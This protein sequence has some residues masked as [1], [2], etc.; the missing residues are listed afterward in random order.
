MTDLKRRRFLTASALGGAATLAMPAVARSEETVQWRMQALW[1]GGTT[2]FE[3]EKKFVERVAELTG[4]KF[5]I[6]LFS[7]GQLVPANQAFDAVRSGAFQMMKTF[8]GYEAGKIPSFAFTS[9]IPFGFPDPDQYEAWFYEL[10]GLDMAREAYGK[11]GLTYVAP[12]VYGEEPMHSTVKIESIADMAGKKGRFVGLA[13]AVM[14]DLGVAVTPMATAEVYSGLEKGLIDF[15]DRGDLTANYEAGLAEVA[16]FII[17]PGVHQPTTAT[18]YVANSAAYDALPDN[19]KAALAVAAREISGSLRQRIIVQNSQV[20]D[21]YR[22][23]GVEVIYL[24]PADV[25]E[26]RSKAVV[27]WKAATKEDP[28]A[29]KIVDSQIGFM[30]SLG[31]I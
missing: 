17:L 10:G 5:D 23:Q 6:K 28:L 30:Q 24:D 14:G 26:A 12:T 16:K 25:A 1:D 13:S 27:S 31:L 19:Y 3:F 20:L 18:S 9:T 2:P 21:K 8:D 4:G 7:A 15:A 11:A 29:T 22:E